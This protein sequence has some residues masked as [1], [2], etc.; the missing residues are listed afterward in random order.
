M[1]LLITFFILVIIASIANAQELMRNGGFEN[2]DHF[3][4]WNANVTVTGA[5]VQP[6]N[7]TAHS[8]SWSVELKSGISPVG[9]LTEIMQT[10]LAPANNID[11]KLTLWIKDSVAAS[12]FLG[13]Y[14]L[15]ALK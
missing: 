8:G 3:E 2:A 11:Y 15:M 14:G 9:G 13:V 12:N 10:L 6:V 4:F 7:T 5:S 1:K